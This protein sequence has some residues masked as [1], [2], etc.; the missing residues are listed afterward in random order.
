MTLVRPWMTIGVL[1]TSWCAGRYAGWVEQLARDL[2]LQPEAK[3]PIRLY[4]CGQGGF[5]SSQILASKLPLLSERLKPTHVFID[6]GHVNSSADT[7]AGPAVSRAQTIADIQAMVAQLQAA[8]PGVDITLC[9]MFPI[10]A[11]SLTIHPAYLDY[12]EDVRATAALLGVDLLDTLAGAPMPLDGTLTWGAGAWSLA[13]T[14]TF[15]PMPD[16]SAWNAADKSAGITLSDAINEAVVTTAGVGT[17]RGNA[18]ITGKKRFEVRVVGKAAQYPGIGI[19][20][21]AHALG[22]AIATDNNAV[23]LYADGNIYRNNAIVAPAGFVPAAGDV[24][25][26]EVDRGAN[27]IYFQKGAARSA[28]V[29]ISPVA[30]AIYPAMSLNAAG[31]GASARFTLTGDGLHAVRPGA[32][33]VWHYPGALAWARAKMAAFWPA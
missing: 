30:G 11:T 8:I 33:D 16:G 6:P 13:P 12:A 9:T 18:A 3:G 14:A 4:N 26:V 28:G 19:A 2:P 21:L 17:I 20:N 5:T 10:S 23:A 31:T 25:G 1:G 27:L 22:A 15:D 32:V 24:I 29:D 7:G